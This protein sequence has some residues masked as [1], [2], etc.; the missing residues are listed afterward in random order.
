MRSLTIRLLVVACL[1]SPALVAA[2][3]RAR[4]VRVPSEVAVSRDG[5]RAHPV[6]V[7]RLVTPSFDSTKTTTLAIES[8]PPRA[9]YQMFGA[10]FGAGA[11]ALAVVFGDSGEASHSAPFVVAVAI[12]A[13]AFVGAALATVVYSIVY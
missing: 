9:L 7:Q 10:V 1:T 12:P 2:Q 3:V 8:R 6:G 4:H 11:A 5:A 13:A